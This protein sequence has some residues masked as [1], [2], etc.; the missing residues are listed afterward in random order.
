MI[1][2]VSHI[3]LGS[4]NLE[5]DRQLF[6]SWGWQF[7]FEQRDI[8]TFKGKRPFM[9]T[10]SD[11]LS[12]VFLLPPQGTPVELIHY[13]NELPPEHPAP[14]QIVLPAGNLASET[15]TILPEVSELSIDGLTSPLWFSSAAPQPSLIIHRVT[16]LEAACRF[17]EKGLGFRCSKQPSPIAG[18]VLLEFPSLMPQWRAS[19]LLVPTE[20][21]PARPLLDGPGF[22]VQ[23]MVSTQF[24]KDR[25]RMFEQGGAIA[26]TGTMELKVDG[27]DLLLDL[28]QGPDG[29]MV[30]IFQ[31][32][33]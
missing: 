4:T 5:R 14:L 23:S 6:E 19:L 3:V 20:G 28:V 7:R 17:W 9:C 12:L 33:R 26:S 16:D 11:D 8:A 21:P 32:L 1:L 2:G 31:T 18:A 25:T 24:E 15:K 10:S 22:R 27:K 30:E 13:A 29:I